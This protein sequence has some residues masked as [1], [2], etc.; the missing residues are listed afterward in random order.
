M[1]INKF[2]KSA[3]QVRSSK[4]TPSNFSVSSQKI[5]PGEPM[6]QSRIA[7]SESIFSPFGFPSL[8]WAF[9]SWPQ[10]VHLLLLSVFFRGPLKLWLSFVFPS[11][12]RKTSTLKKRH[13]HFWVQA[14]QPSRQRRRPCAAYCCS[15]SSSSFWR[16]D[17]HLALSVGCF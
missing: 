16:C 13:T 14:G 17:R 4:A 5:I 15:D 11:N 1:A 2:G 7:Q 8:V 3:Q 12:H 6:T 10:T 9:W